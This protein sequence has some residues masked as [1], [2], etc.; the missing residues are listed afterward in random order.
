MLLERS[1]SKAKE[2]NVD[3]W[4]CLQSILHV[5]WSVNAIGFSNMLRRA[6]F[7]PWFVFPDFLP[8]PSAAIPQPTAIVATAPNKAHALF[9]S[10]FG[11]DF[12]FGFGGLLLPTAFVVLY[13]SRG[14]PITQTSLVFIITRESSWSSALFSKVATTWPLFKSTVTAWISALSFNV[15]KLTALK[16]TEICCS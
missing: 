16:R 10:P 7:S 8:M 5:P 14:L 13:R 11:R 6:I 4:T 2:K 3:A 9:P 15:T 1:C 12:L